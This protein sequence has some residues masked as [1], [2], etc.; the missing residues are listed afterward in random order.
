MT[1][2]EQ[3]IQAIEHGLLRVTRSSERP[4]KKMEL[5]RRMKHYKVPGFSAAFV[6]QEE[7]AWAKGFGVVEAGS[8]KPVTNETI[9][10]AA[11][12]SK[13]FTAMVALH[14]VEAG[15]LDLDADAN[16]FLRSWKI[17]KSK[18]TQTGPEGVHSKVTLRGLLSHTAGI[19][20]FGYPGYPSGSELPTLQ[21]IL[22]GKPPATS[23]PVRVVQVPGT[24][25]KYSGGGYLVVQQMIEDVTGKPLA[26][27]AKEFIFDKLGMTNSTFDSKPPQ[28]YLPRAAT[29]HSKTGEPVPGKWHTY[30]EQAAASLWSTPSDLAR[31]IIEVLKSL[32]NESNHVLSA[33]MTRQMLIPQIGI[34]GVGFNIV[35]KDDMTRFG[36][37]GWNEGFHSIIIG[38]PETGQGIVWMTNGENG[39]RLGR[40]V[41]RGLAEIVGW[42][43]W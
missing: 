25:F 24:A 15:S 43:W 8:E 40:E 39:R 32:K 22:N 11:S 23:K 18:Y 4:V 16:D 29:A 26:V 36:H 41:S 30:P 6:Y 28:A 35:I 42:S 38:C 19:N 5:I 31:L 7:L 34:G 33:E 10:Q 21:Q 9:F 2:L 13:P 17:P 27:L 3:A 20:I 14:L 1:E 12:I 37:P